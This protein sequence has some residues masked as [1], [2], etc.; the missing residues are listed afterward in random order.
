VKR[1][2]LPLWQQRILDDAEKYC[3]SIREVEEGILLT[4]K[5]DLDGMPLL[6]LNAKMNRA[7]AIFSV[8]KRTYLIPTEHVVEQHLERLKIIFG[9]SQ[10]EVKKRMTFLVQAGVSV[11]RI[12]KETGASRATIYRYSRKNEHSMDKEMMH[13]G[14]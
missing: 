4:C 13:L 11:E 7:G 1:L 12:S 8:M 10:I 5:P 6:E 9:T 14:V 2:D 3:E